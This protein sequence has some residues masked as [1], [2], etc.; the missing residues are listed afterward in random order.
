MADP[1]RFAQRRVDPAGHHPGRMDPSSGQS[2]DHLLAELA[3]PDAV[4]GKLGISGGNTEKIAGFR[5]M[6]HAEQQVRGGKVEKAER[7][8]LDEL[9]EVEDA[10]QLCSGFRDGDRQQLVAGLGRGERMADRADAAGAGRQRG[11]FEKRPAFDEFFKTSHLGDL[12]MGVMDLAGCIENQADSSMS[13]NAG[14]WLDGDALFHG[15]L[16]G[17]EPGV[18]LQLGGFPCNQGAEGGVQGVG[19]RRASGYEKID[20]DEMVQGQGM[21]VQ[22]WQLGCRNLRVQRLSFDID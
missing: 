9:A 21:V 13:F 10:A 15:G 22:G 2:F 18:Q 1:C 3:Q 17:A 11:H 4:A 14:D 20:L 7:M 6:V 5:R 12:E 8:R 16:L 19:C